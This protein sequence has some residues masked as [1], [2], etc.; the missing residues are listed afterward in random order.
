MDF[1]QNPAAWSFLNVFRPA[2]TV[3][4]QNGLNIEVTTAQMMSFQI[5]KFF[6]QEIIKEWDSNTEKYKPVAEHFNIILPN[7]FIEG[8]DAFEKRQKYYEDIRKHYQQEVMSHQ[9]MR[10]SGIYMRQTFAMQTLA[11]QTLVRQSFI[12][13]PFIMQTLVRQSFFMLK[14]ILLIGLKN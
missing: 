1:F 9:T 3:L 10:L 8:F 4:L 14:L 7:P 2:Y 5:P 13:Q 12:R 11:V 6:W